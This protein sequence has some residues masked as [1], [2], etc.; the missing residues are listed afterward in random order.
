MWQR[1]I[2]H[3]GLNKYRLIKGE[4]EAI[5][6]I[7]AE[8]QIRIWN[9]QWSRNTTAEAKRLEKESRAWAKESKRHL[10]ADRTIGLQKALEALDSL[11]SS[12]LNP[13]H[14]IDWS[15]LKDTSAFP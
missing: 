14:T 13:D 9:E 12:S 1:E 5:V 7:R 10:A 11:L 3:E 6:N 2:R 4:T 15:S 8:M